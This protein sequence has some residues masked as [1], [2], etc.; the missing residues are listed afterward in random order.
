MQNLNYFRNY[1]LFSVKNTIL[2]FNKK[3]CTEKSL[4]KLGSINISDFK[5][6]RFSCLLNGSIT[7]S[8]IVLGTKTDAPLSRPD[9]KLD[10]DGSFFNTNMILPPFYKCSTKRW[11]K[12]SNIIFF[13]FHPFF[14]KCSLLTGKNVKKVIWTATLH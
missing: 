10:F 1:R 11:K 7:M 3:I 2:D 4:F 13:N 8:R 6:T 9:P 5:D 14:I 12:I